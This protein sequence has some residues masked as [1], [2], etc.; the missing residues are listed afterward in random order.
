MG[1]QRDW[2]LVSR[3]YETRLQTK[4]EKLQENDEKLKRIYTEHKKN[5]Q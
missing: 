2:N 1:E 5:Q 3:Q 4:S